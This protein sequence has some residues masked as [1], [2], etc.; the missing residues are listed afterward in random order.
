AWHNNHHAFP[1]SA[2]LGLRKGEVDPGWWALCTL[3]RLGL[4]WDLKTPA[5]LPHRP[6]LVALAP[7]D[8]Q[9]KAAALASQGAQP[10]VDERRGRNS[11]ARTACAYGR[12]R[13]AARII[14]VGAA[15]LVSISV[16]QPVSRAAPTL[17]YEFFKNRVQPI[18]LQK[19]EGHPRCYICH[20]E[21]NNGFR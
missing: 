6:N 1:A 8:W 2:R 5:S 14:V 18:F 3:E 7:P 21:S 12:R 10:S 19:R 11:P 9:E 15:V 17:D 16:A 4:V 20:A 13:M